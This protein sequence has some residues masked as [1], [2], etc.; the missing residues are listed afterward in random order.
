MKKNTL[1]VFMLLASILT[2]CSSNK[3]ADTSVSGSVLLYATE[4]ISFSV[5][6]SDEKNYGFVVNENTELVWEDKRALSTKEDAAECD[7]W[8]LFGTFMETTVIPGE[9]TEPVE[10]SLGS[11]IKNWRYAKKITVTKVNDEYFYITEAKPV[12]YLYPE[13]KTSV[14][15]KLHYDGNLTCTYPEYNSGWQVT[16]FPSGQ[17]QDAKGTYYNY[18]YWEGDS[19]RNY[20]FSEGFCIKGENT[21]AFLDD[22]LAKLG[23]SRREAN[24]FIVYWLPQMQ[25]NAYNLISFQSDAYTDH[26]KLS[27]APEPDTLIRVFMAWKPLKT[28]ESISP[29]KLSCPERTGFTVVEW[30]GCKVE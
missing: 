12:V 14:S 27:I 18:L 26:A 16:A 20:D 6:T 13:Q 3:K 15:V 9:E 2:A 29:Q 11:E 4:P 7:D 24:E 21:T 8:N 10:A 28:A 19:N 17:L 5:E 1:I 25:D 22:A 23:L 30:G